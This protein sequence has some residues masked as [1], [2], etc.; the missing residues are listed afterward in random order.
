MD[1]S[2]REWWDWDLIRKPPY[3]AV[4]LEYEATRLF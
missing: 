2:D 1:Q 4:V 3:G